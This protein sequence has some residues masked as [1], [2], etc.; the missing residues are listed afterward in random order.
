MYE[1]TPYGRAF[2]DMVMDGPESKRVPE[3]SVFLT[4][5]YDSK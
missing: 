5:K 1:K 2:W 4:L 3:F